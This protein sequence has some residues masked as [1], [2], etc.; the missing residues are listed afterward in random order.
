[1]EPFSKSST[2]AASGAI[3][4]G[5]ISD[6][7][8]AL[9]EHNADALTKSW[10]REVKKSSRT[11]TYAAM[12]EKKLYKRAVH[13]YRQLGKW[14]ARDTTREP[15]ARHYIA[16]GRERCQ[17]GF[18]LSEVIEALVLTRRLLW[19]KV[20]SEGLLDTALE[21]LKAL[22][23]NNRTVYFFDRAMYYTAVGFEQESA[24]ASP[25]TPAIDGCG[26]C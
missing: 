8:V 3:A 13:V 15:I 5:N 6:K 23:L 24:G 22:E 11:P 7:L 21:L 1:M 19:L 18:A 12:D 10:I 4:M 14:I 16:L 20:L 26:E 2:K 17:E 25:G 9:I